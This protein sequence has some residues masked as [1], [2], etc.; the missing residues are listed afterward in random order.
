M[1]RCGLAVAV[2]RHRTQSARLCALQPRARKS[3]HGDDGPLQ[4]EPASS[5]RRALL[6]LDGGGWAGWGDGIGAATWRGEHARGA[7]V[8]VCDGEVPLGT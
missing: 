7:D 6:G 1:S 8:F 3:I 4:P 2:L 5:L